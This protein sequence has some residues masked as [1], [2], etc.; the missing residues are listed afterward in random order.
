MSPFCMREAVVLVN[1]VV[2]EQDPEVEEFEVEEFEGEDVDVDDEV[3]KEG[4]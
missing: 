2:T 1:E 3:F 4:A